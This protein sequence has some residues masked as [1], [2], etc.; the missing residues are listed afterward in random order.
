MRTLV[1]GGSGY[2]GSV[3]VNAL[4][5]QGHSVRVFDILDASDRP[6]G[7]EFMRGDIRDY[8]RVSE[9]C[10]D[11]EW[12]FHNVAQVPLAKDRRLFES[13]NINGTENLCRAAAGSGVAKVIYTSSSAVYGVPLELPVVESTRPTPAEA[14]G[15]A[16]LEGEVICRTYAAQGLDVSIVRPRTILGHG[17]LG[18]FQ[19][20]FEWVKNGRAVPVL[21][22][23]QNVYQFVHASDLANACCLAAA[24]QGPD[25]FNIGAGDCGSLFE[26]LSALIVHADTGSEIRSVPMVLAQTAMRVTSGLGLSP[27]GP[28]HAL[29]YGRSMYFDITKAT[30]K[31]G[32]KPRFSNAQM[33]VDSY[34]AYLRE[35]SLVGGS[36]HRSEVKK[37]VLAIVPWVLRLFPTA[38]GVVAA[39][40]K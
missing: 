30:T 2:F 9:A 28:Y 4:R 32:Y 39:A 18:I 37:K 11:I 1:T 35:P 38:T 40:A 17:R 19:I 29:M 23:G 20:L 25:D 24:S 34:D 7:V 12:I 33:I 14:Y 8:A 16:K 13:V 5:E 6:S 27:L 10:T 3:L 31:L 15:R 36:A 22:H 21:N 26:T